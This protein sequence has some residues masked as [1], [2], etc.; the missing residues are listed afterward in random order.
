LAKP[1]IDDGYEGFDP[2]VRFV[3]AQLYID[4]HLSSESVLLLVRAQKEWDADVIARSVMEGSLKYTYML[5]GKPEEIRAKVH[6][7]WTLLPRF[8]AIKHSDRAKQLLEV[9]PNPKDPEWQ[10]FRDLIVEDSEIAEARTQ[11]S[12]QERQTLEERWSFSGL[13]RA[14]AKSENSERRKLAHLAH[15]YG[16]SSHL[17]HKDADAIGMVW[18]RHRREPHRQDAVRLGHSARLVSDVCAFAQLRLFCLLRACGQPTKG[19]TDIE[20]RYAVSLFSELKKASRQFINVEYEG[21]T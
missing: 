2:L 17:L 7:Y 15:G 5:E 14:F 11:F 21:R 6:E 9:L 16:M 10:S 4:C 20:K 13:C 8:Y 12:R 18:E 19:I 1:Y 3:T